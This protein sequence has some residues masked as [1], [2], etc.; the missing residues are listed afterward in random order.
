MGRV[1]VTGSSNTD[2]VVR[3]ER[4]PRPGQTVLGG[5]LMRFPGGKGANQAVAAARAGAEVFFVG[6]VGDDDFG[7]DRLADLRRDG[8]CLR[9]VKTLRGVPSG[10]AL[11]M[12]GEKAENLIAVAPGANARL[13]PADVRRAAPAFRGVAAVLMQCEVPFDSLVEAARMGGKSG[14]KVIL[15]PAPCPGK[16]LPADLIG[17]ADILVPNETEF[18]ALAGMPVSEAIEGGQDRMPRRL[19]GK[20]IIVTMGARGAL[21][22]TPDGRAFRA[23]PPRV[24]AVDTVGA[25]DCFCGALAAALADGRDLEYAVRFA[26]AAAAISVTRPGAQ[27]SMPR[28]R[29]ILAMLRRR[30]VA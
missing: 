1:L 9:F 10:V 6:A 11:I 29:E 2:L 27:T 4:L 21:A 15:N 16:G 24:K 26:T 25:G 30:P 8:I 12:L 5:D 19:R 20:T 3:A 28:R 13:R 7:R 18:E 23:E 22:I 14:A 17:A